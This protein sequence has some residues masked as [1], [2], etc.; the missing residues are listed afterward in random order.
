MGEGGRKIR[1]WGEGGRKIRKRVGGGEGV[2]SDFFQAPPRPMS[3]NGI[4]LIVFLTDLSKK[5]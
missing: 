5:F 1:N 4:A 3:L 2:V